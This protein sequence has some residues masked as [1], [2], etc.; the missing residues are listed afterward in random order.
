M[1]Q[2]M[3]QKTTRRQFLRDTTSK[4]TLGLSAASLIQSLPIQAK[5]DSSGKYEIGAYYFP[6]Y[7]IDPRNE[8]RYGKNWTEWKLVEEATSRFPGH[9][10]PRV[11][12][13]GPCNE[14][15][16]KVMEKKIDAAADYGLTFWI[17]DWYYYNDGP[18]LNQCL[19]KGYFGAKNNSRI[20]FCTMWAN[21]DWVEIFPYTRGKD[22][23][24]IYPGRV[25]PATF[26]KMTDVL[27]NYFQ[28]PSH[29]KI[30][31]C[32]YFSV[33]D[34]TQLLASFGGI[35]ETRKAMDAFRIKVKKAGFPDL[36]LNAVV[37]GQAVL[38]VEKVP[39]N[40]LDILNG[41]GFDSTTSYV[42]IHHG[43][44]NI[45]QTPYKEIQDLYFK[46][47]DRALT[48][49][50]RPYYP[51]VSVG[52]DSSPRTN[53]KDEFGNW[54]YPFTN[55]IVGNTPEAFKQA[56][57]RTKKKMESLPNNPRILNINSWNE[58]TEGSYLEPDTNTK[59][60][61]LQAIKEVFGN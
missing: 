16:P 9:Q 41:V 45:Q 6:N 3:I 40:P 8:K 24:L 4:M 37:W 10:Q 59:Y 26:E 50:Q 51:N 35:K 57:L 12:L 53:Q 18:F 52:W 39:A 21:H 33:Y 46:H 42:W 23:P 48:E 5:E 34:L 19:E 44:L 22:R 58:W 56:L 49:Y 1:I 32:P 55:I 30:N 7:H 29:F 28:H 54:G 47:W 38:P 15:D 11:P 60:G 27:L 36:H 13:W 20:K 25:T 2:N 14:A 43:P 17:Y 31:G 61:Y